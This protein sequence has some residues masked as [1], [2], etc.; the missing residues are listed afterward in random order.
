[1]ALP[2]VHTV[3]YFPG[4]VTDWDARRKKAALNICPM[5]TQ[6]SPLVSCRDWRL[7]VEAAHC[8]TRWQTRQGQCGPVSAYGTQDRVAIEKCLKPALRR[9]SAGRSG[10]VVWPQGS[11]KSASSWDP[12]MDLGGWLRS[13]GLERYEAAFRD[14]AINEKVLPS[15]TAEDLKELGSWR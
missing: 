7:V 6:R 9:G 3:T 4:G 2:S 1:M 14:N 12:I 10:H 15:L 11:C 5:L 13:L 8:K